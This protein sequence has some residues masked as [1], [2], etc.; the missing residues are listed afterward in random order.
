MDREWAESFEAFLRDMGP[1]PS[2][3]HQI[4][5]LDNDQGYFKDNC[6]WATHK[7]Q[8]RNRRNNQPVEF[9]GQTKLLTEWAEEYGMPYFLVWRRVKQMGWNLEQA[10][11]ESPEG[12]NRKRK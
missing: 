6:R 8:Q 2:L 12:R 7:Q 1:R 3:Q 4:D 9:K 11:T 5:R 10:L